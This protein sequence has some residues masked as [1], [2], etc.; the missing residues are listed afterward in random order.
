M[1]Q[2]GPRAAQVVPHVH[3]HIIPRGGDVPE[4]A[5]KSWTIFGR[6]MRDV[7]DDDDAAD[8][9]R[10]MR[11]R[12]GIELLA[13]REKEGAKAWRALGLDERGQFL[14]GDDEIGR[15]EAIVESDKVGSDSREDGLKGAE[16]N[17]WEGKWKERL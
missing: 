2:I 4:V 15:S 7:L 17:D 11:E 5:A 6:G 3:F 8:L 9:V 12:I 14:G 16:R 10:R 13:I 1:S